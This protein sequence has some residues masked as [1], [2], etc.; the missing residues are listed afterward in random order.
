MQP[1]LCKSQLELTKRWLSYTVFTVLHVL[2][3]FWSMHFMIS[4]VVKQNYKVL[5]AYS[6]LPTEQDV[7]CH[8]LNL[9]CLLKEVNNL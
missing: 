8:S 3:V 7:C 5:F 1:P 4:C 6:T 9:Q 2:V